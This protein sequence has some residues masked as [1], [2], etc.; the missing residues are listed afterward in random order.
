VRWSVSAAWELSEELLPVIEVVGELG[1]VVEA[2]VLDAWSIV[3]CPVGDE[4]VVVVAAALDEAIGA[5]LKVC[6]VAGT[7]V[8]AVVV[9]GLELEVAVDLLVLVVIGIGDLPLLAGVAVFLL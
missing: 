2:V 5:V 8:A 9:G 3:P 7:E 1:T 4:A 6:W